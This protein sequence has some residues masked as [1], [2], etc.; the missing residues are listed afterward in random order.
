MIIILILFF[1]LVIGMCASIV[2]SC[3]GKIQ[4]R[5]Q[6]ELEY[7]L[8]RS[9]ESS[10]E[11]DLDRSIHMT[12]L[13]ADYPRGT[14]LTQNYIKSNVNQNNVIAN[15]PED[16]NGCYVPETNLFYYRKQPNPSANFITDHY[17]PNPHHINDHTLDCQYFQ[18]HHK[19]NPHH[20]REGSESPIPPPPP[21]PALSHLRNPMQRAS[22]LPLD[23]SKLDTPPPPVIDNHHPNCARHVKNI[24]SNTIRCSNPNLHNIQNYQNP[25]QRFFRPASTGQLLH[26]ASLEDP[27]DSD[28][29][30]SSVPSSIRN[31]TFLTQAV[32]ET[33]LRQA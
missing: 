3:W 4:E 9:R 6:R 17:T 23:V 32:I 18:H 7:R 33:N 26:V 14:I 29:E 13:E 22:T 25:G 2:V 11:N 30:E 24:R 16:E 28:F 10:M 15:N 1:A 31:N 19:H 27:E 8:R 20:I 21:P 12:R 5:R